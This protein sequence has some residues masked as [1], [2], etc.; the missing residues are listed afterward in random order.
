MKS[1]SKYRKFTRHLY[2]IF[3]EFNDLKHNLG[4]IV[5][6]F[7][8]GVNFSSGSQKVTFSPSL[9]KSSFTSAFGIA[10]GSIFCLPCFELSV[11]LHRVKDFWG[12]CS[13]YVLL[14]GIILLT[15]TLLHQINVRLYQRSCR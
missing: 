7:I 4:N 1:E 13:H 15:F 6:L 5:K 9:S 12:C 14:C 2:L 11:V 10:Y 8:L 3:K